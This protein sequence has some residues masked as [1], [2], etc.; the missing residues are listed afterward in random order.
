MLTINRLYIILAGILVTTSAYSQCISDTC[1]DIFADWAILNEEIA[2]CEGATFE[3][4][5]QTIMPNIDFYVWDWGNG[6]RDTVYEVSNYFYTY[7]VSDFAACGAV[8]DFIIYNISL[9]IYRSCEEGQSCHTQIAPVAVRIRPRAAFSVQPVVCADQP[10]SFFNETC[11][12]GDYLWTFE[13][14]T[15]STEANPDHIFDEPGTHT[16]TLVVTNECGSDMA[17]MEVEVLDPPAAEAEII[18]QEI[19]GDCGPVVVEFSN[20]SE[21]A[22][23]YT[24]VFPENAGAIFLDNTNAQSFAP[25]VEF[26]QP[27]V[28]TVQ[29]FASNECTTSEW[30]TTVE[31]I[32]APTANLTPIPASCGATTINLGDY[33]EVGGTYDNI[34]WSVIGPEIVTLPGTLSPE[35]SLSNPGLYTV[36]VHVQS[37]QCPDAFDAAAVQIQSPE[38]LDLNL[39]DLDAL[40]TGSEPISLSASVPDGV[41]QGPGIQPNTGLFDPAIAGEGDHLIFY[42]V[43]LGA[44]LL[45]DSI[46]VSV[47]ESESVSALPS[48]TACE[49]DAP[50]QLTFSPAGGTWEGAGIVDPV[51]GVFDPQQSGAGSIELHYSFADPSGCVLQSSTVADVQGL[52]E[53]TAPDITALCAD[54]PELDLINTLETTISP[55][56]GTLTWSGD[57][58]MDAATGH[59]VHNGEAGMYQ[60]NMTYSLNACAVQ[61]AIAINVIE[62][63]IALAGDDAVHC[64]SDANIQLAGYPQGGTWT[65]P[66]LTASYEGEVNI[67]TLGGGVHSFS[68]NVAEGTACATS[69]EV[70]V[71]VLEEGTVDVGQDLSFCAGSGVQTLPDPGPFGGEWTGAGVMN[72]TAGVINI[73]T[74]ASGAMYTYQYRVEGIEGDCSFE[75]ELRI[76]VMPQPEV[77]LA[78]PSP[79]CVNG[80]VTLYTETSGNTTYTWVIDD[81]YTAQGGSVVHT[82]TEAGAY[83]VQLT[84]VNDMGCFRE[85]DELIM[86]SEA[87]AINI[88]PSTNSGCGPLAVNFT[89]GTGALDDWAYQWDFGNG[90]ISADANPSGILFASGQLDTTYQ[91]EVM[92]SNACGEATDEVMVAVESTPI[93]SFGTQVVNGC[94]PLEVQFANTSIGNATYF[95][96]ELGNGEVFEG[97]LPPNQWYTTT[98]TVTTNY[99]IMLVASNECG[100]DVAMAAVEVEPNEL[101]AF[102]NADISEGCAP[103][104]VN[105]ADYSSP[106]TSVA[107]NFGDGVTAAGDEVA[108]TFEDPG[109]YMVYQYVSNACTMDTMSMLIQVLEE[110][111]AD[112][113]VEGVAC[114]NS[115]VQFQ[116]HS[117][118]YQTV[119]WNFGDGSTS[120]M[121]DPNHA[122]VAPGMYTVTMTVT[123]GANACPATFVSEVE[124]LEQPTINLS[125]DNSMGCPPLDV[126]FSATSDDAIFYEWDFGD[127]NTNNDLNPCHTFMDEG[128]KSVTLRG[129]DEQ[130]C[131]SAVDSVQ[132][133][134]FEVPDASFATPEEAI[135]GFPQT[136]QIT[137]TSEGANGFAWYLDGNM[138]SNLTSPDL[139]LPEAGMYDLRLVATN[140]FGC[141]SEAVGA[142][143]VLPQPIADFAAFYEDSCVPQDVM[144][145]NFSSGADT[146]EW[147]FGNGMRS[148]DSNPMEFY[149]DPGDY[150]IT[151]IVGYQGQCYDTLTLEQAVT[152]YAGPTAA[153]SWEVP[154]EDYQGLIQ[155]KNESLNATRFVWDF[156]DGTTSEQSDPLH[157][158]RRNGE[159]EANLLAIAENG[160]QDTAAVFLRPD[161][162]YALHFPNAFSPETG[163]GDVRVFKPAGLGLA[164]WKLEIFSPWGERVFQSGALDGDE[165]GVAWDGMHNG[166]ILPQGAY[167]YKAS[168]EFIN[169]LRQ[170]YTGSVTILR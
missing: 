29:L 5:N 63:E 150:D 43:A 35:L 42:N 26:T 137:N 162:I 105:F 89:A 154:T 97:E 32:R 157:D 107:W 134:V 58:I 156:G 139:T 117:E 130:G 141:M 69:D 135:C 95:Y 9:E 45:R 103:L 85:V 110:P 24:W 143:E 81:I 96:W 41:W 40:C 14:G 28:H 116:N 92:V 54:D 121:V 131:A 93:A 163:M 101:N 129:I 62:A 125:A 82:F 59:F 30:T 112:F 48:V 21:N 75:D 88:D 51:N 144:F 133:T 3:V 16:V 52:P 90:Q 33:L 123:S 124:V 166:K 111:A 79:N 20:D 25:V 119:E 127:G 4:E 65:G 99:D 66:G 161:L 74:L 146:Y 147:A 113:S 64:I 151:L 78:M 77:E 91:V 17:T 22:D 138:T 167:A 132:V 126:C 38:E 34:A 49:S 31:V 86:I 73:N 109:D 7:D 140:A 18:G 55:A 15:T 84:A 61:E 11:G 12:G 120:M 68:Y 53:I 149:Y 83:P 108:H 37:Q 94:A 44:C 102:F 70:Y 104:T 160:C 159:W 145:E 136:V 47:Q 60:V 57:G 76:E 71:T 39:P 122:Y 87:P 165:P 13:D 168:V 19:M 23:H 169:G 50:I 118:N 115:P 158:Y 98:D 56:G 164:N 1:G 46:P 27:G 2:I 170:V 155:F 72:A 67:A 142:V 106:G 153:F 114:E 36:N 6:E 80:P 100:E 8:G 152:L 128:R 10:V 148:M